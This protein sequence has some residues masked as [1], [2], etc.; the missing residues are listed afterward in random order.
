MHSPVARGGMPAERHEH[1]DSLT[2]GSE[3]P[4][5]SISRTYLQT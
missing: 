4:W 3:C 2:K 5:S 1:M